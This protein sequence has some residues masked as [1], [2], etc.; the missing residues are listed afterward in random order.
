MF[1][2]IFNMSFDILLTKHQ[3]SWA[4]CEAMNQQKESR[5][6]EA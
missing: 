3:N 6:S 4:S 1:N 2:V 5:F